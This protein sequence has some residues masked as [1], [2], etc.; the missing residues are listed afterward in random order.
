M[1]AW[2]VT[3]LLNWALD[4]LLK[5]TQWLWLKYQ[6]GSEVSKKKK[7]IEIEATTLKEVIQQSLADGVITD[8]ERKAINDRARALTLK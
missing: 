6:K 8:E 2:L 4:K 1:P 5:L 3:P 7:N